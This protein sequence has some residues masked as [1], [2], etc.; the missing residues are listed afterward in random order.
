MPA[1]RREVDRTL[2]HQ[3][4]LRYRREDKR[5]HDIY[6]LVLSGTQFGWTKISRGTKYRTL[7]DS[8]LGKIA[9]QAHLSVGDLKAAIAC[10]FNWPDY[11]RVLKQRSPGDAHKVPDA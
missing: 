11:A 1:D 4:K 2:I 3:T 9:R 8:T 5:D 10:T 7:D 6:T